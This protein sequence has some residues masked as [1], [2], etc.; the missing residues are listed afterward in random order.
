MPE[1]RK[2][3]KVFHET[4]APASTPTQSQDS[5]FNTPLRPQPLQSQPLQ[6]QAQ[7]SCPPELLL[8][9]AALVEELRT[10]NTIEIIKMKKA[11]Q[12]K[13]AEQHSAEQAETADQERF[14]NLCGTM[15]I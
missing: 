8:L 15:Y 14:A 4:D 13:E 11:E 12:Q 2:R 6:S 10:H 7:L 9:L 5:F 3:R 1:T